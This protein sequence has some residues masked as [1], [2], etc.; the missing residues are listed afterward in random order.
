M[1]ASEDGSRTIEL[2]TIEQAKRVSD[3]LDG[4]LALREQIHE[5]SELRWFPKYIRRTG[6]MFQWSFAYE[7]TLAELLGVLFILTGPR[8]ADHSRTAAGGSMTRFRHTAQDRS[9]FG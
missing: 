3:Q 8:A 9:L 1:D 2:I 6:S 7:V 5:L 4:M